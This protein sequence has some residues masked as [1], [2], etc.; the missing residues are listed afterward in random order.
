[1]SDPTTEE[2]GMTTPIIKTF[3]RLPNR[4]VTPDERPAAGR[5]GGHAR[6][7][8]IAAMALLAVGI[9]FA[10]TPSAAQPPPEDPDWPCI[11]RLVPRIA[12][13]AV[14]AGPELDP[15]NWASD[16][17]VRRLAGAIA[18][19]RMPVEE[20][21]EEIAAFAEQ[22]PEEERNARLAALFGRTLEVINRDRGSLIAGIKRFAQNQRA[23]AEMIRENRIAARDGSR[24]ES[25][26]ASLQ[27]TLAWETRIY[28]DRQRS[29][30]YLCEQPVLLDQRAF[31]LG[32][33]VASQLLR[34]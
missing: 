7:G 11:Q 2:A 8:A 23:R 28:E 29:L 25:D 14:W 16:S 15:Q 32:S 20:A 9:G 21:R 13:A 31:A 34:D 5:R 1:M 4:N 33:A 19:R 24:S 30:I 22:L 6:A 27:E 26:A 12:E 18:L 10:P 3:L 17:E